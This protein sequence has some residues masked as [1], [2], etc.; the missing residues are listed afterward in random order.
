MVG[1]GSLRGVLT[2]H[3]CGTPC[4]YATQPTSHSPHTLHTPHLAHLAHPTHL[5]PYPLA[6]QPPP[7]S[8]L[9]PLQCR[10]RPGPAPASRHAPAVTVSAAPQ[11]L[12]AHGLRQVTDWKGSLGREGHG[13]EGGGDT[14]KTQGAWADAH[15]HKLAHTAHSC[16]T[17]NAHRA[18]PLHFVVCR[19]GCAALITS[20]PISPPLLIIP[21]LSSSLSLISPYISPHLTSSPISCAMPVAHLLS[22]PFISHSSQDIPRLHRLHLG[23]LLL[24]LHPT[25]RPHNLPASLHPTP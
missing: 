22:S 19:C 4:L 21:H 20:A 6:P 14:N 5:A 10:Q 11:C 12:E 2:C 24:L 15:T 16:C 8:A 13:G 1:M 17:I 7:C 9:H 3:A 18:P 23:S 25:H